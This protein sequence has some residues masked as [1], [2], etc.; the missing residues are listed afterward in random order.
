MAQKSKIIEAVGFPFSFVNS[1]PTYSH[2]VLP[3]WIP[4][5]AFMYL[6]H[7]P[8]QE[9][10]F[11]KKNREKWKQFEE[12]IAGQ[13]KTDPDTLAS[14]FVE[15]TDD[16]AYARTFYAKSTTTQYLNTLTARVHQAIYR[17]KREERSRVITFWTE[18]LPRVAYEARRDLLYAFLLT[19]VFFL[20]GWVSS[21]HDTTY[22]RLILGDSYVNMS[23]ENMEN[24]DPMG[25]YKKMPGHE[26][27]GYIT[28]NNIFVSFRTFA[29]GIL[30]PPF[31]TIYILLQNGVMLG[32]FMHLFYKHGFGTAALLGVWIHGTLEI[33]AIII[34]GGAGLLMGKSVIF[35]GT[36]TRVQSFM[37]GAKKGLKIVIG[38]IP[39]FIAAGFLESFVTRYSSMPLAL[40]LVIIIG[41]LS[42][43]I[44]YFIIYPLRLHRKD[45]HAA[46]NALQLSA[47]SLV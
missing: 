9:V 41:S 42:F 34:A 30:L 2:P 27:F 40:N 5:S 46:D 45:I 7:R 15:L 14:L 3:G 43:I 23:L 25:V 8:M 44:W 26:M 29:Y 35:P 36:Y 11:H 12:L 4:Y 10:A 16:L 22:V 19:A 28:I 32:A 47:H 6:R 37:V 1:P 17:N 38:L 21:V 39:I 31:G 13:S 33:S 20:I 18:E 24:N